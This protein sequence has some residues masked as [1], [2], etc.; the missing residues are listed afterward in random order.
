M[1]KWI[2]MT[3][4]VQTKS[5]QYLENIKSGTYMILDF[6]NKTLDCKDEIKIKYDKLSIFR[7]NKDTYVILIGVIYLTS[8][9]LPRHSKSDLNTLNFRHDLYI[10]YLSDF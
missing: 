2:N 10:D 6:K 7:K 9:L 5:D 1:Y 3:F 4:Q 8:I